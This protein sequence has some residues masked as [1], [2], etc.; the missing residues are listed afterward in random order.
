MKNRNSHNN[1]RRWKEPEGHNNA[2]RKKEPARC[3]YNIIRI[4]RI[5][6][7]Y[8]C[9]RYAEENASGWEIKVYFLFFLYILF[10]IFIQEEILDSQKTKSYWNFFLLFFLLVYFFLF[11][12]VEPLFYISWH[13][14]YIIKSKK[15]RIRETHTSKHGELESVYFLVA[16]RNKKNLKTKKYIIESCWLRSWHI[17]IALVFF[18][19]FLPLIL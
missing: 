10:T 4:A 16:T 14:F 9:F 6:I 7:L 2:T 5:I 18:F 17:S 15:K 1:S 12:Q 13:V 8:T 3:M 19:F 11:V